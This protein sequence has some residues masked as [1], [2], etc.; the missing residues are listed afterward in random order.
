MQQL[1][2][3]SPALV[4]FESIRHWPSLLMKVS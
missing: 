1:L 3:F 4:A 2:S